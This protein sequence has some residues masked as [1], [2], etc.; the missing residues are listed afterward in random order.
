MKQ[1][2]KP[3]WALALRGREQSLF[4]LPFD[5]EQVVCENIAV[6]TDHHQE[7]WYLM[8]TRSGSPSG[9]DPHRSSVTPLEFSMPLQLGGLQRHDSGREKASSGARWS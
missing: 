1:A 7:S 6:V 5:F 8:D 3:Q 4:C 9:A 2:F